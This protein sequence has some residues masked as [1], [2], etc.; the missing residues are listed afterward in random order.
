[1]DAE[2][3]I[4]SVKYSI[5][6]TR[7]Y[8]RRKPHTKDHLG[9]Q[10]CKQRRI[11]CDKTRPFC[12]RCVRALRNCQ[13]DG[14][15]L[16]APTPMTNRV[17]TQHWSA[18]IAESILEPHLQAVGIADRRSATSLSVLLSHV[19]G[20]LGGLVFLTMLPLDPC[21]WHLCCQHHHL[22][23]ALLAVSASHLNHH[24]PDAAMHRIAHF[25]LSSVAFSLFRSAV[26]EQP[27]SQPES[28]AL[29]LTAMMLNTLAFANVDDESDIQQS[30][31]Y[32]EDKGRLGWLALQIGLKPLLLATRPF[33]SDSLL[34]PIFAASHLSDMAGGQDDNEYEYTSMQESLLDESLLGEFEESLHEPMKLS[35]GVF[36]AATGFFTSTV[37]ALDSF[38]VINVHNRDGSWTATAV[39]NRDSTIRP[40]AADEGLRDPSSYNMKLNFSTLL[41]SAVALQ[42]ATI[43]AAA[44]VI[45]KDVAV[46]DNPT[47]ET[48]LANIASVPVLDVAAFDDLANTLGSNETG[49]E[50]RGDPSPCVGDRFVVIN[51]RHADNTWSAKGAWSSSGNCGN[52]IDTFDGIRSDQGCTSPPYLPRANLDEICWDWRPSPP[53]GHVKV[54][55]NKHCFVM[56]AQAELQPGRTFLSGWATTDCTW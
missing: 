29:L 21:L 11:K 18:A 22:L 7:L 14:A 16:E 40:I 25:G 17:S 24:A 1:M 6:R 48:V 50:A 10:S 23:A 30:W 56:L 3:H 13:Y 9:C 35:W 34:L 51:N 38:N 42:A 27:V 33:R 39:W 36:A 44:T 15:A 32:S 55:V 41:A 46:N 12:T 54:G 31:V 52:G 49:I 5:S 37:V 47:W 2:F 20:G 53:R 8:R 45:T 28:D 26:Q 4:L 19:T 43:A